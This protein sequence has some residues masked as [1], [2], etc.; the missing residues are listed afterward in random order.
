VPKGFELKS[1][2][3]PDGKYALLTE[4]DPLS[5][6]VRRPRQI[7][8]IDAENGKTLSSMEVTMGPYAQIYWLPESEL[9]IIGNDKY[10]GEFT[11]RLDFLAGKVLSR[12]PYHYTYGGTPYL[13]KDRRSMLVGADKDSSVTPAERIDLITGAITHPTVGG[14]ECAKTV[15]GET[16]ERLETVRVPEKLPIVRGLEILKSVLS[17]DGRRLGIVT[18]ERI[19]VDENL[20]N[21]DSR[22]PRVIRIYATDSLELLWAIR[23]TTR[24][25]G[26]RF[27]ADGTQ[28]VVTNDDGSIERWPLPK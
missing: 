19:F 25:A 26:V 16:Y 15:A 13:S 10:Q 12:V 20:R 21:W 14:D 8:V 28:L 18:G 5:I 11:T 24:W 6:G 22:T 1:I 3:E 9:L 27:N 4:H 7:Q 23:A 17:P 2:R